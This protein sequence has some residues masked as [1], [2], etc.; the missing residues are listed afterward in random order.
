MHGEKRRNISA[1]CIWRVG[2]HAEQTHRSVTCLLR[3]LSSS[4]IL[5]I[6]EIYEYIQ[7]HIAMLHYGLINTS[8]SQFKNN[9]PLV[10]HRC[11]PRN[12]SAT[13]TR[14]PCACK[15]IC[16]SLN[17]HEH[18]IQDQEKTSGNNRTTIQ[19]LVTRCTERSWLSMIYFHRVSTNKMGIIMEFVGAH[20]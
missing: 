13:A 11:L 14:T 9:N 8:Y 18:F 16:L 1:P 20:F 15:S 10:E 2:W 5:E 19:N 3:V 12:T 6:F 17:L 7:L 4:I